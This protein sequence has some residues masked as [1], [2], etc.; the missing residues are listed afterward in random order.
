LDSAD[1][2]RVSLLYNYKHSFNGFAAHLSPEEASAMDI[3][4]IL[5]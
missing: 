3:S 2:A 1:E 4:V 5:L